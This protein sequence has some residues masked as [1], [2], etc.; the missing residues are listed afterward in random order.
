VTV[1]DVLKIA[2][3]GYPDGA[4]GQ[5]YRA[6]RKGHLH[7]S[8]KVGDTLALAVAVELKETQDDLAGEA[9]GGEVSSGERLLDAI[10]RMETFRD[11][12]EGVIETL[13]GKLKET[14]DDESDDVAGGAA[15]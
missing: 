13:R 1:D 8:N 3:E 4:V 2:D 7:G 11:E 5:H 10:S 9:E 6:L 12:I 14:P 15:R